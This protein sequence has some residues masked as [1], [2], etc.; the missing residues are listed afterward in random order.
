MA[1]VES[2]E[3]RKFS[4]G[5]KDGVDVGPS[6]QQE[7]LQDEWGAFSLSAMKNGCH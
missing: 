4:K 3:E 7:G 5:S 2:Q 1:G 6:C